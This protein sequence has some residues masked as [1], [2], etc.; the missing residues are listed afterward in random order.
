MKAKLLVLIAFVFFGTNGW[1]QIKNNNSAQKNQNPQPAKSLSSGD[2]VSNGLFKIFPNSSEIDVKKDIKNAVFLE[3]DFAELKKIKEKKSS[4]LT[5]NIPV[6]ESNT[7][8]F[9]LHDAKLLTDD[10]TVIT[11]DNEKVNYTPGLYYQGTVSGITPSLAA[12]SVFD[13]SIMAV[14]SY[15][16]ENYV[17]GLWNDKSNVLNNIYILYKDSDVLFARNFKCGVDELPKRL[18]DPGNTGHLLSNQCIKIYFECDR[19]MYVDKGNSATN[20]TN[21]VTGIFNSVQLMY[22]NETISTEISQVY[23]WTTV[24]PYV[25]YTTSTDLLNHFQSTRTTFNGTVAHLL[26]TRNLN[27][28]GLAFLD[29]ICSPGYNYGMSNIDNTY[30]AYPTFSWSTECVTHELG[31]NFGSNHTH[32]CGWT[33]GAIDDCYAVEGSC[34]P[35]PHPTNGGTIMSYCH[36]SSTGILLTNG[37]GTQPGNKIRSRYAAASCLTPCLSPPIVDFSASPVS[38]CSAPQSVT[39]TDLSLATPTSWAWDFEND[40]TTDATTQNPT[41]IYPTAGT[42]S[43]KL[44]ATNS[45][46][47]A[48]LVK[49]SYITIGSATLP[50]TE[51]FETATFPPTGW[52]KTQSPSDSITWFRNTTAT[53]NGTSTACA[54]ISCFRYATTGGEKDN[55]I[56]KPVSL[57]GVSTASMTFKVAYKNFPNPA[58]YDTLRVFVSSN[59]GTS[60]GTAVYTKGGNLLATSGA[61]GTEFTPT[62]AADW[63]TEN[64]SLN[65]FV[66]GNIVVK[67]EVTNRYGNDIYIDD[68]NINSI[69]APSGKFT[70]SDTT[71]C[72]GQCISFTDQSTNTPNSWAWTFTGAST[73]SSTVQSPTNICYNTAGTYNVSLIATNGGGSNTKTKTGYIVV[74]P[75]ATIPTI[76]QTGMTLTS[77]SAVSYQWNKNG[78]AITGATSISYL[79]TTSGSYTVT[80]LNANG[81]SATSLAK[82]VTTTGIENNATGETTVI[83]YPDPF[84]TSAIIKIQSTNKNVKTSEMNFILYDMIGKEVMKIESMNEQTPLSRGQLSEGM[85][86]YKV[87]YKQKILSEG[88]VM[89]Q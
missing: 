1:G 4:L 56:S 72:V 43:V 11:G 27:A 18:S 36:L 47:P 58:N 26:T 83:I 76:T 23:V 30:V 33:G 78:V 54:Y 70:A 87:F 19:Q 39:F 40:G 22:N 49:T 38:S 10:F 9:T 65:S 77:S 31:H 45:N 37:F 46:G 12:W 28:G 73:T 53:G 13:N 5:L 25:S 69:L 7:V 48:T 52:N 57:V 84:S 62:V 17:V 6:S 2:N 51:G 80:I 60:Y 82:V 24:D 59:C 71:L 88:K 64:I 67:F 3:I 42:Y 21:Y 55:L 15:N 16:N 35:G 8:S 68:I 29:V 79:A 74:S 61:L 63:R 66:G 75:A 86:F 89:I 20:V 44:T 41:H 34:S 32:W 81:C 85:Y 14:F 50:F